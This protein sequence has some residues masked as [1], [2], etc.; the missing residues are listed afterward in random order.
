MRIRIK[1]PSRLHITLI[2]LNGE[3]GRLDGGIGL[4][5]EKPNIEITA[6]DSDNPERI[7]EPF[8]KYAER[9][10]KAFGKE[11]SLEI[12][13]TYRNHVGLGSGTQSA[14]AVA[15]AFKKLYGL[16]LSLYEL[17]SLVGRGGTSGIGIHAFKYGGF[18]LDGGHSKKVKK[19]FLPSSASKAPPPPLLA[20]Y[21]FPDWDVV[22][23]IPELTGSYG[24]GEV[25]L[26][27]KYCPISIN[28]VRML[29]H[30]ILM[31]VLPSIVEKDLDSFAEGISR[32]Q[33]IGFKRVEIEQYGN[34]IWD[35][36]GSVSGCAVGMS[37]T[38]PTVYAITDSNAN[39]VKRDLISA[40]REKNVE[41]ES[42]VTKANNSGFEEEWLER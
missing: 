32:I 42:L 28:E 30:I 14:L 39:S 7:P 33:R 18:I 26:F 24:A 17:A 9:L 40:F 29:S 10:K 41:C 22:V 13:S 11:I 16:D 8:N 23:V 1:T 38:G 20:R 21:D 5:L 27:Q 4:A 15:E 36:M 31:K 19:D 35:V 3:I 34:L 2:D 37:S 12:L 6:S 25:N